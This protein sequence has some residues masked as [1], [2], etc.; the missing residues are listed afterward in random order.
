MRPRLSITALAVATG[1]PDTGR[2]ITRSSGSS[3]VN[4]MTKVILAVQCC[5][6][7]S[8]TVLAQEGPDWIRRASILGIESAHVLLEYSLTDDC[9]LAPVL[10]LENTSEEIFDTEAIWQIVRTVI[11]PFES[12]DN[13]L[14]ESESGDSIGSKLSTTNRAFNW[15]TNLGHNYIVCQFYPDGRFASARYADDHSSPSTPVEDRPVARRLSEL[16]TRTQKMVFTLDKG[17]T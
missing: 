14:I 1:A 6:M 15:N 11:G 4:H 5:A 9:D 3:T 12:T 7:I 17:D 16:G 2:I 13:D 10:V 8:A